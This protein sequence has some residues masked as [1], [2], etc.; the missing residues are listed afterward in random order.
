M[1]ST[2]VSPAAEPDY[3]AA[4]FAK[5]DADLAYL[6]GCLR[7]VLCELDQSEVAAA[8][9]WLDE[10]STAKLDPL[11]LP[12]R[13][14]QAYALSFQLLNMIEENTAA[15]TRRARER[16]AGM[17]EEK[18]LWG[19]TLQRLQ[20]QGWNENEIAQTLQRVRVEPVLTVHPT[21]AKRATVLEQHRALYLLL[22]ERENP[23]WTRAEHDQLTLQIKAAIER[24]WRTGEI[25]LV[26]PD[27]ADERRNLLHYL[28]E[29]FPAA[30]PRLDARLREAWQENGL[31]PE[32]LSARHALP[33]LSFGTWAGGDRDGHPFVT[34]EVTRNTL[35][36]LR[37]NALRVLRRQLENLWEKMSLSSLVQSPPQSLQDAIARLSNEVGER[38]GRALE[39]SEEEPWRQ[40]VALMLAKMPARQTGG[41]FDAKVLA[42]AGDY[43]LSEEVQNDLQVLAASLREVGAERIAESDVRPVQRALDV[44]GLHLATLDIR[45]NSAWHDKALSQL[46]NAAQS[47]PHGRDYAEWSEDERLQWLH[48]ELESPRPFLHAGANVGKEA[49]AVL[50]CYRVL[51]EHIERYGARG[52]GALI[53][54]MTRSVSDLLGVYILAREAG[55]VTPSENGLVCALPVVPLFETEADL[56]G[57][58]EILREFLQHPLT[59]RSLQLQAENSTPTQQVMVGYSDSNKDSGILASQWA[60]HLGQR[61]MAKVGEELAVRIRFFHGRGGTISRG[62]GPT[63]RFLEALPVGSLS[64]DVRLTEQG[65]TIAQKFANQNTA[66]YN[67]ELLLAGTT[68]VT[69]GDKN[70]DA[71]EH[72]LEP[73]ADKLAIWSRDEYKKLLHRE[74]FMTFFAGATPIDALEHAHIGSRPARRTGS[75]SQARTIEDLRAIPWVFSWNQ[76]RFYLPGWFG[77]GSALRRLSHEDARAFERLANDIH[78]W[79]FMRYVLTNV[80]TTLASADLELMSAYAELVEDR[81]VRTRFMDEISGEWQ[82]SREMLARIFGQSFETRRPR[83]NETLELRARAL[84]LLHHQQI[85]LLRQWRDLR[86]SDEAQADAMLPQLLLSINAIASGLR[87][88]G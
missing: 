16:D 15:Q 46:M 61:Q 36:E 68:G 40:M 42:R 12:A 3:I 73:I 83:M 13:L 45:Q 7:D 57:G 81:E 29:V 34:A 52:L 35:L 55:L 74:G 11:H 79:P 4:G 86:K 85:A 87:T 82:R 1:N 66:T 75:Q 27:I 69:L 2:S 20:K 51:G 76:A 22:F 72:E 14:G 41:A 49:D 50:N 9:P 5:I 17:D 6:M 38:A 56:R 88:T 65:E 70:G 33:D 32:L 19:H 28:R 60:L 8:L 84:K 18:G 58:A 23:I 48:K 25:L 31:D 39:D 71:R 67:L 77:L 53:V 44:F 62:A 54:S 63:H 30:L 59:Q 37:F 47:N 26:K 64:G 80:E 24:L 43:R 10:V 21:E 78:R